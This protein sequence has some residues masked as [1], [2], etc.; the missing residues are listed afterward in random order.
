MPQAP[1]AGLSTH[2]L[3]QHPI[4][5][6][7]FF[8]SCGWPDWYGLKWFNPE[9]KTT[10]DSSDFDRPFSLCVFF[11]LLWQIIHIDTSKGE[12]RW[13]S[14]QLNWPWVHTCG[15]IFF[16]FCLPRG[17]CFMMRTAR[18]CCLWEMMRQLNPVRLKHLDRPLVVGCSIG[19]KRM[20]SQQVVITENAVPYYAALCFMWI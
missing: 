4:L 18:H 16:F 2:I 10:Q 1:A 9:Q 5:R 6:R 17:K 19:L 13:Q 15:Y 7:V 3:V 11:L 8:S 12:R 14:M 20:N